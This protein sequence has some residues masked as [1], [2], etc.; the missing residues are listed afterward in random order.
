[1]ELRDV[2]GIITAS[3]HMKSLLNAVLLIQYSQELGELQQQIRA[4]AQMSLAA[5]QVCDDQASVDNRLRA[6]DYLF[7]RWNPYPFDPKAK[8]ALRFAGARGR[9]ELRRDL[10]LNL[11]RAVEEAVQTGKRWRIRR[12]WVKD[13]AGR[14]RSPCSISKSRAFSER[15]GPWV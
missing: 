3:G 1:M 10:P 7:D 2:A 15:F 11:L 5:A 9:D 8:L 12:R 4:A 13:E 6:A 14:P